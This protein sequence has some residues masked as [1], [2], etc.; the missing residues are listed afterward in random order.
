[1]AKVLTLSYRRDLTAGWQCPLY[2]HTYTLPKY[3]NLAKLDQYQAYLVGDVHHLSA[4][5]TVT[6]KWAEFWILVRN[7][8][9][10]CIK[11]IDW[12]SLNYD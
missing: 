7:I 5:T 10:N 4:N 2:I 3:Q 12:I 8:I 1:M 6:W 9:V 11:I